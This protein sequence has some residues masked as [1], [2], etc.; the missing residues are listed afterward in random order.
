MQISL[1]FSHLHLQIEKSTRVQ[2]YHLVDNKWT[3]LAQG[4]A[5][6]ANKGQQTSIKI[7][8]E[9]SWKVHS[10]NKAS[11]HRCFSKDLF[12]FS[13]L[14]KKLAFSF[15]VEKELASFAVVLM[16]PKT[17]IPKKLANKSKQTIT[18]LVNKSKSKIT[19]TIHDYKSL[20][21]I[22]VL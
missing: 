9:L 15:H 5:V 6:L 16:A 12:I 14:E 18:E 1:V 4:F 10:V 20:V 8:E 2:L 11:Q 3:W 17:S 13:G 7:I 22:F 21:Y 19:K